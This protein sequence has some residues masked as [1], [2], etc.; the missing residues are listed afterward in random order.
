MAKWAALNCGL[1]EELE[2][3]LSTQDLPED[4]SGYI[5]VLKKG[6]M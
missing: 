1:S 3:I 4:W 2:D 5:V 6:N